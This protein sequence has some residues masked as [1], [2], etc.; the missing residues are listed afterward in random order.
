MKFDDEDDEYLLGI[1]SWDSD[2]QIILGDFFMNKYF[3]VY[4]K[5][6][7]KIGF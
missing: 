4:D 3:I 7:R 2:S 1:D 5:E 6:N